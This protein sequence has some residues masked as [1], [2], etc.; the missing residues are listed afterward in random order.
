MYHPLLKCD[1]QTP[2]EAAKVLGVS[3]VTV[4]EWIRQRRFEAYRVGGRFYIPT[5]A[6]N[7]LA[8]EMSTPI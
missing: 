6:V 8:N 3:P 5:T 4:V 2:P 1:V 7:R